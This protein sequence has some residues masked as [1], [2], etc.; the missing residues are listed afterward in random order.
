MPLPELAGLTDLALLLLRVLIG[1]LFITS[2]WRHAR[3]PES[4]GDS[5]GLS[6]GLTRLLGVVE[7]AGGVSVGIG[8]WAQLGALLLAGVM[9]GAIY[10]KLFVW[11]TGFWGGSAGDGWFYDLLYLVCALVIATTG[12]GVIVTV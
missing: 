8:A 10:K 5:L 4:R 6:P 2:G 12:G 7:L 1:I 11:R 3:V 9:F